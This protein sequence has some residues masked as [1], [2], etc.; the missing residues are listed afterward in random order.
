MKYLFALLV[1]LPAWGAVDYSGSY[2]GSGHGK[3]TSLG[4]AGPC[5]SLQFRIRQRHD[6][7]EVSNMYYACGQWPLHHLEFS[8]E[9]DGSEIFLDGEK[10]G[11]VT[12]DG[13][14]F[15]YVDEG[16]TKYFALKRQGEGKFNL[17]HY[18]L[19]KENELRIEGDVRLQ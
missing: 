9:M 12:P 11:A 3:S 5:Q 7:M 2:Y 17:F 8:F 14:Y 19:L 6:S 4:Y 18:M 10:V 15:Q 13:L 1:A 16:W